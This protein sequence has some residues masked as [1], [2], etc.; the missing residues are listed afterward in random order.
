MLN[1]T[2]AHFPGMTL[3]RE[4]ELWNDGYLCWYD[5]V[6]AIN[7]IGTRGNG[8]AE[9][10]IRS[11]QKLAEGDARF[12]GENLPSSSRWRAYPEF[13]D[14][15]AFLDIETTGLSP[16]YSYTTLVG[17]LD[18]DGYRAYLRCENL[19]QLPVALRK[20]DLLVTF[21]GASFDLPF[22]RKEFQGASANAGEPDMFASAIHI[23]LRYP[24]RQA[25]YT[26]G[27]K[28]IEQR[29]GLGRPSA[30]SKLSGAD[31]VT[32]WN[33]AGEG[34]PDAIQT[35]V[36]YNAEDVASLPELARLTYDMLTSRLPISVPPAP[37]FPDYDTDLLPYDSSLVEYLSG[38]RARTS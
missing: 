2:F 38:S 20:Y 28:R 10:A 1:Y 22:L 26:G 35:L 12:F 30:L 37:K 13:L 16:D 33:M 25:G 4:L 17:I 8:L 15:A 24:L 27:L 11:Q 5:L 7:P 19:D 31:A 34:E 32:L 21:N 14:G 9:E 6:R 3:A 36:R 23:D 18:R 29:T